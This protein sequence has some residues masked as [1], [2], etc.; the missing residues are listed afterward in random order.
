MDKQYQLA[1]LASHPIQY[2]APLFRALAARHEIDL[3]V[4]FCWNSIGKFD[5]EFACHVAWDVP[6]LAGYKYRFLSNLSLRP[7][8]SFFGQVNPT[9][10]QELRRNHYDAILLQEYTTATV[11]FGFL[12]ARLT[13]TPIIF[14]GEADLLLPR[15][16][17][18][19]TLKRVLLPWLFKHI[20]AF[21]YSCTRNANY[22]R[23]YGVPGEKLFFC[24]CAVDNVFWQEQAGKFRDAKSTLKEKMG[25]PSES[26]VILFVGKLIPGKRPLDLLRAFAGVYSR[27]NAWLVFVGDGS[28]KPDLEHYCKQ[29]G[30]QRVLLTGFKNQSEIAPFYAMA[31]IFV[32]ASDYDRS[33]KALNEAMNFGI[34]VITTD[35]VGTAPDLVKHGENGFIYPVG[36]VSTLQD[37]LAKLLED[38][39]FREQMGKRSLEI[40]SE[41]SFEN[42]VKGILAA[43]DY[44]QT[45]RFALS[46]HA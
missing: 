34:P 46:R 26:P 16:R 23:H 37:Y 20:D 14:R 29:G 22:Y 36:D 38:P 44:I 33:P 13:R 27:C 6:L 39:G 35:R 7:G 42:D 5:P 10:V 21:L 3:T 17:W 31:D 1:V 9:I 15:S 30:F 19:V 32:L 4:Y 12:E 24:P 43:L 2:H 25:T 18:R 41:W 45:K 8:P 11:W 40:V 28:L